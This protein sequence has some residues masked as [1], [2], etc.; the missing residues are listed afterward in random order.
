MS[1][2]LDL[3]T[4]WNEVRRLM[5]ANRE[6]VI[7]VAGLFHFLPTLALGL[8]IPDPDTASA[9]GARQ[10]IEVMT[11]YAAAYWPWLLVA[12]MLSM[13]GALAILSAL[14]RADRPTVGESLALAAVL[15]PGYFAASALSAM[16]IA[17]G[18]FLFILPGVYLA[19]RWML[20]G[21]VAA[22]EGE[23]NPIDQL[24]GSWHLTRG[25]VLQVAL[26]FAVVLL[27]GVVAMA[28]FSLITGIV[29]R[30]L[31]PD[32][33]SAPLIVGADSLVSTILGIVI[34]LSYAAIYRQL[35]PIKRA[36]D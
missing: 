8:F 4:C 28:A 32:A 31:L 16:A 1:Q 15:L 27:V 34:L 33:I 22:A 36:A 11:A 2:Q 21:A 23:R 14:L 6:M 9:S 20:I 26:Y 12:S 29:F 5:V 17:G 19:V 24:R 35:A 7:A 10:V 13:A 25:N 3:M 30:L 18:L